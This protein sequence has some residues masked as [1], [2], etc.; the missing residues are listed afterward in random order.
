MLKQINKSNFLTTP[1]SAVKEWNFNNTENDDLL[2]LDTASFTPFLALEYIDY[3]GDPIVNRDCD[4]ALEQQPP[5]WAIFEEGLKGSGFF[6]PEK[7]SKNDTGTYKR[8]VYDQIINAFYNSYKNPLEIFGSE[9]IDFILSRMHRFY[10]DDFRMFSFPTKIYGDSIQKKS[11]IFYDNALD[12][13][14]EITDDGYGNLV[15]QKYLFSKV[16]EVRKFGNIYVEGDAGLDCL[17]LSTTSTTSTSTTSTSTTSTSTT[18]TTSTTTL[19]PT[20]TTST[21][22]TPSTTT[23]TTTT[24]TSTTSTTSPTTSTTSTT[25][26]TTTTSTSTLAPGVACPDVENCSYFDTPSGHTPLTFV[27]WK[28]EAMT[29]TN[30]NCGC[31]CTA[32]GN[33]TLFDTCNT[34]LNVPPVGDCPVPVQVYETGPKTGW[35][36]WV[37]QGVPVKDGQPG[38]KD[39]S[40]DGTT[41]VP[42]SGESLLSAF[43]TCYEPV[44]NLLNNLLH[45]GW[46]ITTSAPY[47]TK[48]SYDG[49]DTPIY[50]DSVVDITVV[51]PQAIGDERWQDCPNRL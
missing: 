20:T 9:N 47:P 49:R 23:T 14:A 45:C 43:N 26:T 3:Y 4:I 13:F 7:E 32:A 36:Y 18:S 5:N 22:T 35:V 24:P 6:Y 39:L 33:C 50:C 12:D 28:P 29:E 48:I 21:S 10:A 1:F 25:P 51:P 16:Q 42:G 46:D 34:L 19:A 30:E 27:H 15:A 38:C 44:I 37:I 17:T 11:V 8:L 31:V 41:C 2:L 40:M